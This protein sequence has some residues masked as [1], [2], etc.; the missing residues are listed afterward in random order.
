MY[1]YILQKYVMKEFSLWFWHESA[2]H[3]YEVS[4]ICSVIENSCVCMYITYVHTYVPP[5]FMY[6]CIRKCILFQLILCIQL[7]LQLSHVHTYMC[8]YV[9]KYGMYAR[10]VIQNELLQELYLY[11]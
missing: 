7:I 6:V 5:Y 4:Q 9:C 10:P 8:T 1:I 11:Y 3:M 2:M